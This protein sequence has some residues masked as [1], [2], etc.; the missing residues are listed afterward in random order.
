MMDHRAT[1]GRESAT[2]TLSLRG[3]SS[4]LFPAKQ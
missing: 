4:A 3:G 2:L 1:D